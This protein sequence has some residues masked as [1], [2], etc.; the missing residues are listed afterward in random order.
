MVAVRKSNCGEMVCICTEE[1]LTIIHYMSNDIEQAVGTRMTAS[2]KIQKRIVKTETAILENV[3]KDIE[4]M[5][6]MVKSAKEEKTVNLFTMKR[7][8]TV[9][10]QIL[11]LR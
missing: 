1:M 5:A 11:K 7:T 10:F 6:G 3:P 4:D 8:A 9:S 2:S